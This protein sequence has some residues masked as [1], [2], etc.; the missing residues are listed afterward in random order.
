MTKPP[1]RWSKSSVNKVP[2]DSRMEIRA[3]AVTGHAPYAALVHALTLPGLFLAQPDRG[4]DG[5]DGGLS[6]L[7]DWAVLA[8][9]IPSVPSNEG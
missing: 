6:I 1:F 3:P 5:E 4:E 9:S 7:P 8:Q 2:S